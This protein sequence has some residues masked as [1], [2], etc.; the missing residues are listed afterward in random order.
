[1]HK[2]LTAR[3]T[4]PVIIVPIYK[5]SSLISD[6]KTWNTVLLRFQFKFK[7]RRWFSSYFSS[8][9]LNHSVIYSMR[10]KLNFHWV[11]C[12]W[13]VKK[14]ELRKSVK[15][16]IFFFF[17][18]IQYIYK[19]RPKNIYCLYKNSKELKNYH[20][21]KKIGDLCTCFGG[22]AISISVQGYFQQIL[23]R[24]VNW[25]KL[26]SAQPNIPSKN[27]HKKNL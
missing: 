24:S 2:I 7:K 18:I 16:I 26:I 11:Q 21:K 22:W 15:I 6:L 20:L 3:T 14:N 9:N 8:F 1:M 17:P 23:G 25:S 5:D 10:T 12:C 27:T 19:T 4:K 13:T